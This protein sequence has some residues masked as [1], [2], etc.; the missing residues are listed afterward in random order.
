MTIDRN[1]RRILCLTGHTCRLARCIAVLT[2]NGCAVGHVI[3]CL[4]S[5]LGREKS[6]DC[7]SASD[8]EACVLLHVRILDVI[9]RAGCWQHAVEAR[10]IPEEGSVERVA[11]VRQ[12]DRAAV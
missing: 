6:T 10:S 1:T 12:T 8:V 9:A 2:L 5:A 4:E 7:A 3:E 11:G